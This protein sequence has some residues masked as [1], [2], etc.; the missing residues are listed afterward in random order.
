MTYHY[1][2]LEISRVIMHSVPKAGR[3]DPNAEPLG[4]SEIESSLTEAVRLNLQG[5]FRADLT[6]AREVIEDSNAESP[7]PNLL[8]DF[9]EGRSSDFVAM[10][11]QL[12]EAL[13]QAQTGVN[14]GGLLLVAEGKAD[15]RKIVIIVKLERENGM[16]AHGEVVAGKKTFKVEY[17]NDILFPGKSRI[18]KIGIF[19]EPKSSDEE[20]QGIIADKQ[21]ASGKLSKFFLSDFLGFRFT[22]DAEEVTSR[23]FSETMS[24]INREDF[25]SGIKARYTVALMAELNNRERTIF[26]KKFATANFEPAHQDS[27]IS[28]MAEAKVHVSMFEKDLTLIS[29]KIA[30]VQFVFENGAIVIAPHEALESGAV[31]VTQEGEGMS[32][33]SVTDELKTVSSQ[34]AG[35]R[36][37]AGRQLDS[38]GEVSS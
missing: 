1:P 13:R 11:S 10:S 34:T 30:K 23:F 32:T 7:I 31:L 20:I 24:W 14:S 16:R 37:Q 18:Y 38:S 22:E 3:N 5:K 12:A 26:A 17:L 33:I 8:R 19:W 15:E 28:A 25:S 35:S 2:V 29:T 6:S 21:V 9:F 36:K 4:L 27:Y